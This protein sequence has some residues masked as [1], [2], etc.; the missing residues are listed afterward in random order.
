MPFIMMMMMM[1]DD[2]D[3]RF[4]NKNLKSFK[5]IY[6]VFT[7]L[8]ATCHVLRVHDVLLVYHVV[9]LCSNSAKLIE[10]MNE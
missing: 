9:V 3:E 6:I 10:R 8:L 7:T 2:D 1:T 5:S 4:K